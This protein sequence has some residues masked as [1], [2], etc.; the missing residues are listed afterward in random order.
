M[1]YIEDRCPKFYVRAIDG[2]IVELLNFQTFQKMIPQFR[3]YS[4]EIHGGI[5]EL[6]YHKLRNSYSPKDFSNLKFVKKSRYLSHLTSLQVPSRKIYRILERIIHAQAE[7]NFDEFGFLF[8]VMEYRSYSLL[9]YEN[10][11]DESRSSILFQVRASEFEEA[12][13]VI[14]SFFASSEANKRQRLAQSTIR[15]KSPS[16]LA[17]RRIHHTNFYDWQANLSSIL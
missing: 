14:R 1:S 6:P 2:V 9:I 3:E 12:I 8:T 16:I 15:I 13:E 11:S 7:T 10:A 4:S 5:D 17:Y